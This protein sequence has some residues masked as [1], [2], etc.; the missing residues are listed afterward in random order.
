[1]KL[2]FQPA[3]RQDMADA[4]QWYLSQGGVPVAEQF[5]HALERATQLLQQL[6]ALVHPVCTAAATG[7]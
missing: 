5:Q 7:R 3:A 2:E 1:M 4:L 6:P